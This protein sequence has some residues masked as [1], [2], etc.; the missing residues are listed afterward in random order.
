MDPRPR[1]SAP[2]RPEARSAKQGRRSHILR[3]ARPAPPGFMAVDLVAGGSVWS[4][5]SD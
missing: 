1:R 4:F 2:K 5:G 3:L